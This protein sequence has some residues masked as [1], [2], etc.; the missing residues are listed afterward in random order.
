MTPNQAKNTDELPLLLLVEDS[1]TTTALL[2]KYFSGNYRLL[3]ASDGAEAWELLTRNPEIALVITD[4][5]MP[6][7]T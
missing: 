5:N 2:S 3:H 7:M 6:N 1:P 4:I